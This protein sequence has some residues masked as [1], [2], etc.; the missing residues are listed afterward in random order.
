M[1][2]VTYTAAWV[3]DD[4][5]E[6]SWDEAAEP[7]AAW[8]LEQA[9]VLGGQPLLVTPT[10]QQ[11]QAGPDVIRRFARTYEATTSRGRGAQFRQRP[12]LAYVPDYGDMYLA[13]SYARNSALAVVESHTAPLIGWAMEVQAVDLTTGAVTADTRSP[14]QRQE[15]ERIHGY[16]NNGWTRGFGADRSASILEDLLR[17]D[18]IDTDIVVGHMVAHGHDK[19]SV[20][21]LMKII[22]NVR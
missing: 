2:I 12:V 10:Q 22:D 3:P 7:A 18:A 15:L 5:P 1:T 16:G 21:R 17:Q 19:R 8:L 11:W 9:H 13:A 4:D 20:A 14:E 6:R